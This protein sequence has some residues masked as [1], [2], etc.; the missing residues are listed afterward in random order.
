MIADAFDRLEETA[1]ATGTGSSQPYGLITVLSGTGPV[2]VGSS[3]AAGAADLVANDVYLLDEA[4]P[5]RWRSNAK[6]MAARTIYN[7]IRQLT[8]TRTN[9]WQSFGGGIPPEL[10]GYQ[11]LENNA[12]DTTIVSGSNDYVL[13]LGDFK[14]YLVADRVGTVLMYEPMIYGANRLPT[15]QAGW[16]AH[17]R[18]GANVLTSNAFKLLKV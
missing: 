16:Y 12:F 9:F 4:L 5:P 7:D 6:F 10:I 2:V 14:Q 11:A 15:G 3:G 1:F 8:D 13:L 18:T 17:K